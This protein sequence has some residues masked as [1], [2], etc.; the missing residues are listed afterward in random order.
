MPLL[1]P[2]VLLITLTALLSVGCRVR[3]ERNLD[4]PDDQFCNI[5]Q[6]RC[7]TEC[8]TNLDCTNPPE[9]HGAT[10]V[11]S[12]KGL[13]CSSRGQCLR[14]PLDDRPQKEREQTVI[15]ES[16]GWQDP[17][18]TGPVFVLSQLAIGGPNVGFDLDRS[19]FGGPGINNILSSL[20]AQ[21]LGLEETL[22]RAVLGGQSV[23]IFEVA[24]LDDPYTGDDPSVT[25]KIYSGRD[26]DDPPNPSNNF[27]PVPGRS[28]CCEFIIDPNSLQLE[29]V[30][31]VDLPQ[32]RVRVAAQIVGG[33][34]TTRQPTNFNLTLGVG[35]RPP[36]PN[37]QMGLVHV[38]AELPA[39]LDALNQGVFGGALKANSLAR[40]VNPFCSTSQDPTCPP[41]M[42]GMLRSATNSN[43]DIDLD[44]DGQEC[45]ITD[46]LT[47]AVG[48]CCDG[49]GPGTTC[50]LTVTTCAAEEIEPAIPDNP[51]S[52]AQRTEFADGYSAALRFTA[53]RASVVGI[54]S[55]Q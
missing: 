43:P 10:D 9:C 29:R 4:C 18:A 31:G 51:A 38:Y 55:N 6:G 5:G 21:S 17:P 41:T 46:P 49:A 14:D 54:S 15:A 37:V 25:V 30:D 48:R 52:C 40:L 11:C 53:V 22:N 39:A 50:G 33:A 45:T 20:T 23:I 36:Y 3:C 35:S 19:V 32:A 2:S 24:G 16:E 26:A 34:L 12:P 28:G 8:F 42:L 7:E 13:L 47:G 27:R 44:G 1:K